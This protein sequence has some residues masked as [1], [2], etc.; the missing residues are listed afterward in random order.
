MWA[1][2]RSFDPLKSR[3]KNFVKAES[4]DEQYNKNTELITESELKP[5]DVMFFD[6]VPKNGFIDHVAM[7]VGESG[8]YD[9][10]NA[11]SRE[12]GIR[13][14]SKDILKEL[15]GFV[16]FKQVVSAS[17]PVILVSAHSPVDII[18]TDP[19]GFTITPET[20]VPSELEFLRQ[21]PGV[22]YYSEMEQGTDGNPI[23]QIYSYTA[24]I[25]DYL[26]TVLP[27]PGALPTD[28]YTLEVE[29][30]INGG[31]VTTILAEDVPI[32][33][34]PKQPYLVKL[35]GTEV[36]P[37]TPMKSFTTK[38]MKIHWALDYSR[39]H[40]KDKTTFTIS[41]SF[42]LP[43]NYQ[44]K[45]LDKSSF[46]H[47]QIAEKLGKDKIN[48]KE[49]RNIWLY[50]NKFNDSLNQGIDIKTAIIHW[51]EKKFKKLNPF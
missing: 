14:M 34:I 30:L 35:T 6:N 25:G 38:E 4:A 40:Q 32:S 33:E 9:V 37:A 36:I 49:K 10:V 31:I 24:K 23:D 22:L 3:F 43:E 11:R 50:Q 39:G 44:R 18:V 51:K 17:Q 27:E 41:G 12:L 8:G 19:D 45:D 2:N 16:A 5:G 21:I 13:G 48:F 47:L 28:I 7:Y 42:E 46:L 29:A 1:F 20:V 26:I 15:P